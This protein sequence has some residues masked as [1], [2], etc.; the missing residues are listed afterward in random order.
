VEFGY[1]SV[2]HAADAGGTDL[3]FAAK[4]TSLIPAC[5]MQGHRIVAV[6]FRSSRSY[7]RNMD[8]DFSDRPRRDDYWRAKLEEAQRRYSVDPNAETRSP[9]CEERCG[10]SQT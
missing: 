10:C 1:D 3:L 4:E 9:N 7:S 8:A 6:I 2:D 5:E